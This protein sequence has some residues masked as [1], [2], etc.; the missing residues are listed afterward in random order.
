[1]YYQNLYKTKPKYYYDG[2]NEEILNYLPDDLST[3]LDVGCSSGGFGKLLK[4]KGITVWGIEPNAEAANEAKSK[5]DN[6]I[7]NVFDENVLDLIK[8]QKFDCIFF[9]D[10]LEHFLVLQLIYVKKC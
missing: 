4:D 10:V 2:K 1:M 8:D 5:I 6:V 7:N 3:V 9:I